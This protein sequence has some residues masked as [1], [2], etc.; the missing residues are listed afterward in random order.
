MQQHEFRSILDELKL[1][2]PEM[3]SVLEVTRQAVGWFKPARP[4]TVLPGRFPLF[5]IER[6]RND[7]VYGFP[8]FECVA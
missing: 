6:D 8:D 2:L 3:S 5:I 7:V 1:N 4:E